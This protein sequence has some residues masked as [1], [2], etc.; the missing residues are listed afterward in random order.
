[1]NQL[2]LEPR[3]KRLKLGGMLQTLELRLDQAHQEKL[4][5]LEFLGLMLEDEIQRRASKALTR[6]IGRARFEEAQSLSDFDFAFNP[7][8]PASQ[9][10]DLATCGFIE[11][12]E[13]VLLVG[14]VGV[15][16]THIA[17]AIGHAACMQGR[18]VLFDKTAR[19]LSD[20]GAGHLDATWERRLRRYLAPD[21]LILDDFGLRAF[22]E[23]QGEDLYELISERVRRGS[24]IVTSNRPPSEWY[25]LF[26]NPVLAEG[27]LDRLINAAHHVTLEGKSFRPRQRPDAKERSADVIAAQA[28]ENEPVRIAT[29]RST[30]RARITAPGS[31][32]EAKTA[33]T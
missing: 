15:G 29:T 30:E 11:R 24:T 31:K 17:Q 27:A 14:P 26:P 19:V 22:S 32:R 9:I 16:K 1:M 5:H 4:G 6:R 3:L 20:L 23:R 33:T 25:A 2:Q 13:S 21:L 28:A 12:R 7:K 10:R 18:A 8:I